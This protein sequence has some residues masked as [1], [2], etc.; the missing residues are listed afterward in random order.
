MKYLIV[1]LIIIR[2]D[3]MSN[4]ISLLLCTSPKG[5]SL[6]VLLSPF[7]TAKGMRFIWQIW[8]WKEV[9]RNALGTC[10]YLPKIFLYGI[11]MFHTH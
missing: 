7:E 2:K 10:F 4:I 5:K 11:Y 9:R 6:L 8:L 1:T 3:S